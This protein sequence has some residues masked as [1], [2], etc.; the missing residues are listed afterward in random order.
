MT[1][2]WFAREP[3]DYYEELQDQLMEMIPDSHM[4]LKVNPRNN[5]VI[6]A[7]DGHSIFDICWDTLAR[8]ILTSVHRKK[9]SNKRTERRCTHYLPTLCRSLYS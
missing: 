3:F 1:H 8:M 7:A 2:I 6:F 4:R 5:Q 9:V